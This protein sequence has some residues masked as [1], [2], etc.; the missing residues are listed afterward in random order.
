MSQMHLFC[1]LLMVL[2]FTQVCT[3]VA[4]VFFIFTKPFTRYSYFK[5][6]FFLNIKKIIADHCGGAV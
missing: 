6:C 1:N 2:L 4:L 3:I 5:A